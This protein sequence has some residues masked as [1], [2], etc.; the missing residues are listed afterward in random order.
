MRFAHYRDSVRQALAGALTNQSAGVLASV[1]Q[2]TNQALTPEQ[3]NL[4][5]SFA[6]DFPAEMTTIT[7]ARM[8]MIANQQCPYFPPLTYAQAA[9]QI[10]Y[11]AIHGPY[12]ISQLAIDVSSQLLRQGMNPGGFSQRVLWTN[13]DDRTGHWRELYNWP[14][15]TR[16][17]AKPNSQLDATQQGHLDRIRDESLSEL[18]D[19]VFASGRRSLESLCIALPTTDRLR[20]PA[21]SADI[22]EAADGVIR[23]LGSRKKLSSHDWASPP[24]S[25]PAYV[26]NYLRA[27]AALRSLDAAALETSVLSHLTSAGCLTQFILQAPALCLLDPEADTQIYECPQCR[28][29]HMHPA[30][31]VC[32]DCLTPLGAPLPLTPTQL[33][34][35]YYSYLATQNDALFRLNC[36]ELTGQTNKAD[37]RTRQRLFQDVVLPGVENDRTDPIDLLSVTTT[38]E[39]GVDIGGLLAV[40]MAN[41]P[42]MRFNYQQRVG[43]AGRRGAG[44]SVALTLCRGRS[45]DDYYFQRP[46]RITA[47]PPPQP[48]VDVARQE[49][50]KRVLV[51]EVLRRA[52][53]SLNLFARASDSVH[54]EFGSALQWN[55][56]APPT[57]PGGPAGPLVEQLVSNWIQT[58]QAA[59][60]HTADVLLA[61]TDA[62]LVAARPTLIAFINQQLIGEITSAA[63]NPALPQDALSE[64]LANVGLLPMFGFPTRVRYLF[65]ARPRAGY[66]WP[67]EEGIVDR[68]LDLAIS[69]FAPGAE[70]VKD[71]LIHTSVGVVNYRPQGPR[72]IE[73]PNPLGPS[74][75]IGFC[76]SCQA[77]DA[78]VVPASPCP[79]CGATEQQS[80]GYEVLQL[81]E[82]LGFRTWSGSNRDFDGVFEWTPRASRPKM[83]ATLQ[84][85]TPR[86]NFGL[87]AGPETVFVVNDNGGRCFDFIKLGQNQSETWIT[88]EALAQIGI[89]NVQIDGAAGHDVRALAS[90]K[91][92]DVLILGIQSW[93]AGIISSPLDVNCRAALYSLGFMIRRAAAVRL[94]IDERELKVGLR[95]IQDM[96]AVKGELFISDSLENGAGYSSHLGIPSETENLLGFL[97]GQGDPSFNVPLVAAA[98]AA[99]CYTSCPDCL[100][101][102]SNL[103]FHNILDWRLGLDLAR[104]ALDA[105]ATIDFTVPYWLGV[106]AAAPASYFAAQQ[107]WQYTAFAGVP[108]G[109][110]GSSV[111]IIVHP[112]WNCAGDPAGFCP[113]LQAAHHQAAAAGATDIRYKSIFE[114]LRRPY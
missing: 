46:Q 4:A 56:P 24:Q 31:G 12:P 35:D 30:G 55:Q 21:A 34:S 38:M 95:V 109:R 90:I 74:R 40:M 77:V 39:A 53:E 103:A 91:P 28:R 52:F 114:L 50:L 19:I 59:V 104:L 93:P 99:S 75:S 8:P 48:Y 16:P 43:R 47:D 89:N 71:G 54:G 45:H 13:F 9:Q 17:S 22:Q 113:A 11:R 64:R 36:E 73:E 61:H 85:L 96:G 78:R 5:N 65:H 88:R 97:I 79:V 81:S 82:P 3:Q 108:A 98:H 51:K 1:A 69:Q 87:W 42:P 2:L 6:T 62:S 25:I 92:T 63:N 110:R 70:T 58:N 57:Q 83:A 27:V 29:I 101:D 7:M 100:R 84:P 15:G 86:A 112:L 94:D 20:F 80:P 41:M 26:R 111:E 60:A 37:G 14:P 23:L 105:A 72:V 106:A 76:R 49:I 68:D 102:F 18:M 33:L 67:P 10:E 66:D 44:L 32:T 107:Q